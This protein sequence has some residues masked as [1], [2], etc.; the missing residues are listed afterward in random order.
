M[1]YRLSVDSLL[2]TVETGGTSSTEIAVWYRGTLV[3][4]DKASLPSV[5]GF[6]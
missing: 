4:R 3:P 5:L 1:H 6:Y 2:S